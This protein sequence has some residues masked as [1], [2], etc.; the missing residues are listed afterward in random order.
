MS[1]YPFLQ[2]TNEKKTETQKERENKQPSS[3]SA[4]TLFQKNSTQ[5]PP[6]KRL[7]Y[8]PPAPPANQK[9]KKEKKPRATN[10]LVRRPPFHQEIQSKKKLI[11]LYTAAPLSESRVL[12]TNASERGTEEDTA[13][14]S[15]PPASPAFPPPSVL[16]GSVHVCTQLHLHNRRDTLVPAEL[17]SLKTQQQTQQHTHTHTTTN[18]GRRRHCSEAVGSRKPGMCSYSVRVTIPHVPPLLHPHRSTQQMNSTAM[19][20]M[21]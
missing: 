20:R 9:Q 8:P 11:T 6:P 12:H 7:P 5:S 10:P 18:V 15:P 1:P 3:E 2:Q 4:A 14:S 21:K 16:K 19:T 13:R 17:T